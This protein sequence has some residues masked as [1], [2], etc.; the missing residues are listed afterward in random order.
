MAKFQLPRSA[1]FGLRAFQSFRQ[2]G[3]C[4]YTLLPLKY[5]FSHASGGILCK[6]VVK[7]QQ[8]TSISSFHVH[9]VSEQNTWPQGLFRPHLREKYG[10]LGQWFINA[11]NFIASR[12]HW[13]I[14]G[15]YLVV[16]RRDCGK[17]TE[18]DQGKEEGET[19]SSG[20]L[21]TWSSL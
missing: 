2:P 11:C 20:R 9:C 13:V 6:N 15:S 10:F 7:Q 8:K 21:P 4:F 18:Q 14:L 16:S 5:M 19:H 1:I 3:F 12:Y 17:D